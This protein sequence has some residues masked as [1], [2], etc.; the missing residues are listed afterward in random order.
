MNPIQSILTLVLLI[1]VGG[2]LLL[3]LVCILY[4]VGVLREPPVHRVPHMT[5]EDVERTLALVELKQCVE[6]DAA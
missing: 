1:P 5:A 3:G 6:K 2:A 4:A